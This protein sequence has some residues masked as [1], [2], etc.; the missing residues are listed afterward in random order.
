[1]SK[2]TKILIV[3]LAFLT[4]ASLGVKTLRAQNELNDYSFQYE[5][6]IK[7]YKSFLQ[8]K[9]EYLQYE[10]LESQEKMIQSLKILLI[11]R[12]KANRSYFLLLRKRLRNS[13]GLI[14]SEK[15]KLI[16]YLTEEIIFLGEYKREIADL[17]QIKLQDL[18]NMSEEFESK[19]MDYKNKSYQTLF[20]LLLGK[21]KDLQSDAVSINALFNEEIN[22]QVSDRQDFFR[23][24]LEEADSQVFLS[25]KKTDEAETASKQFEKGLK[26]DE[27]SSAFNKIKSTIQDSKLAL[28]KALSY[29]KELLGKL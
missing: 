15:N 16:N 4:L 25:Q 7:D 14:L 2:K 8:I 10:T 27:L 1:M 26:T 21:T 17:D 11:Q 3:S 24:W 9:D 20:Y 6:Y 29:Q 5:Q 22:N 13:P 12:A 23:S 19:E 28:D 18:L